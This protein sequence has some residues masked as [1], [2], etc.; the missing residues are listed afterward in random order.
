MN[1][2]IKKS[3]FV[4]CIF[5][6]GLVLTLVQVAWADDPSTTFN[7]DIVGGDVV[8]DIVDGDG[9]PVDPASVSFGQGTYDGL[10]SQN[11][12]GDLGSDTEII[13]LSNP[14][15]S[16][17]GTVS[18]APTGDW[19]WDDGN[20]NDYPIS[21]ALSIEELTNAHIT[22]TGSNCDEDDISKH[23]DATF[24][25]GVVTDID[26]ISSASADSEQCVVDI[27][28]VE[29]TQVIPAG[30]PIGS[31]SVSMTLSVI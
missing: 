21:E 23:G 14:T 5:T 24:E 2:S 4:V 1:I 31:Y 6:F 13:R 12:T 10:N 7:Q 8:L 9:N 18:I 30:I 3:L 17:I 26:L 11:T 25:T 27:K 15:T 19:D 22:T 16:E 20:G 28:D 29:M